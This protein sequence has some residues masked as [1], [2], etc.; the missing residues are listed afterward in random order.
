MSTPRLYLAHTDLSSILREPSPIVF[1]AIHLTM[2]ELFD[3]DEILTHLVQQG[4][5]TAYMKRA[6]DEDPR[7]QKSFVFSFEF[8]TIIGDDCKPMS[9]QL[10]DRAREHGDGHV[11]ITRCSSVVALSLVGEPIRKL[12]NSARRAKT[13]YGYVYSPW[14]PWHVLNIECYPDWKS[15]TGS[16]DSAKHYVNGPEAFLNTLLVE[17]RDAQKRFDEIGHR[18]SQLVTPPV[19]L[20]T[21]HTLRANSSSRNSCS[22]MD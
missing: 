8:F 15:N 21:L 17:F 7:K 6:F 14:S 11:P 18:I 10:S 1:A 19:C 4:T 3:M 22:T 20:P 5:T 13:K 12:K 9:W 2:N 16:H